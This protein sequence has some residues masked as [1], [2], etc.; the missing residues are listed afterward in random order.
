M[1]RNATINVRDKN[2][3][4]G[5][6]GR[7]TSVRVVTPDGRRGWASDVKEL[8][9]SNFTFEYNEYV[10]GFV[11][12]CGKEEANLQFCSLN[13]EMIFGSDGGYISDGFTD[14]ML[15]EAYYAAEK[16]KEVVRVE[17]MFRDIYADDKKLEVF[18]ELRARQGYIYIHQ[19]E[20]I[21]GEC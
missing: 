15:D 7:I 17:Q 3:S 4:C 12:S 20:E 18:N 1:E 10:Q 8:K 2:I 5:G 19:I 21:A 9:M 13:N 14:E 6:N 11:V 16:N